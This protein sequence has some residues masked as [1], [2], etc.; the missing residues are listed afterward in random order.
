MFILFLPF[1]LLFLLLLCQLLYFFLLIFCPF[2]FFISASHLLFTSLV[3]CLL[4]PLTFFP[5]LTLLTSLLSPQCLLFF[6]IP[7]LSSLSDFA[8]LKLFVKTPFSLHCLCC[9]SSL[10]FCCL[11]LFHFQ[12]LFSLCLSALCVCLLMLLL[13]P[14]ALSSLVYLHYLNFCSRY[15]LA[16]CPQCLPLLAMPFRSVSLLSVF[17]LSLQ[18]FSLHSYV[19]SSFYSHFSSPIT[20]CSFSFLLPFPLCP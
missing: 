17:N 15:V 2:V 6:L 20:F 16:V 3:S 8:N 4:L 18:F 13:P 1:S 10:C 11:E 9:L 19:L 14:F 5:K 12:G 7:T